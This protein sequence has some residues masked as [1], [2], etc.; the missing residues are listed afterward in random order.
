MKTAIV[1]NSHSK[2][3]QS[4]LRMDLRRPPS[5]ID[6]HLIGHHWQL[7]RSD[8][9]GEAP[10]T[11]LWGEPRTAEVPG[12]DIDQY[13][14]VLI[15]ACGVWAARNEFV[16]GDDR[17][18]THPLGL[19]ARAD[20]R[21]IDGEAP[22]SLQLVSAAVFKATMES[23]VRRG[24]MMRLAVG[25]A[26]HFD[27]RIVLQPWPAP[28]R[29]LK[30]DAGWFMNRWYGANGPRAWFD[31]FVVQNAAIRQ[32]AEE[33]GSRCVLLDHP[34]EDSRLDGFAEACWRGADPWHGNRDYGAM[35]LDQL[36]WD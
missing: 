32:V 12:I 25:L 31:Y 22:A 6:F 36:E 23:W 11:R 20:W 7:E 18:T 28:S 30:T 35:V 33:I 5:E 10:R 19:I 4:A 2:A 26:E 9:A 13:G 34:T 29:A 14:Q 17:P 1:G 21:P 3:I 15:S 24:A 8:R 27:G 16:E